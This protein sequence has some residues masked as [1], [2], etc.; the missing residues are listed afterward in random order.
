M[1]YLIII[2]GLSSSALDS[3]S[4]LSLVMSLQ[5][6]YYYLHFPDMET[7]EARAVPLPA[8][9]HPACSPL[10]APPAW[11]LPAHHTVSLTR[12]PTTLSTEQ[13]GLS[14]IRDGRI[15]LK[16]WTD[17]NRVSWNETG[18][19]ASWLGPCRSGPV[20]SALTETVHVR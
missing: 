14:Q 20:H 11:S 19:S 12:H 2:C 1:L 3:C 9:R 10:P 5:G 7:E 8:Q 13:L 4:H 15:I 6:T 17:K 18:A 16:E